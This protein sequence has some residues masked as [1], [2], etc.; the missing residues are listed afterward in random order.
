MEEEYIEVIGV[1]QLKTILTT[2]SPKD[3]VEFAYRK[4]I[5]CQ[6]SGYTI[7][8]LE[9]G[10]VSGLGV[11][12]NQLPLDDSLFIVLYTIMAIENPVKPEDFLSEE[13]LE[14]YDEFK[15]D[16]PSEYTPDILSEFCKEEGIDED[17]RKI[18]VLA[19]RFEEN[20]YWN[21]NKWET[22]VLNEYYDAIQEEHYTFKTVDEEV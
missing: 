12:Q 8:N 11:E 14:E 2:L 4:W 21:Y 17:E 19:D 13:E 18:S 22:G 9:T 20:E 16:D 10:E 5:P 6:R 3:I 7:L 1:E 15:D